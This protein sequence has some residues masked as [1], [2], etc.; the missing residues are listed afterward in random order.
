MALGVVGQAALFDGPN[1]LAI[2]TVALVAIGLVAIGAARRGAARRAATGLAVL[3]LAFS[4]LAVIGR[5]DGL[6][7]PMS[8]A[9]SLESFANAVATAANGT[10]VGADLTHAN[11]K[12][13]GMLGYQW[14]R[15]DLR[16][17][18]LE[19]DE[20]PLGP[21][22]I[23]PLR[24]ERLLGLGA[25]LVEIDPS[26]P[27]GLYV[28]PGAEQEARQRGALLPSDFPAVLPV[29]AAKAV[30]EGPAEVRAAAG[31]PAI[32]NLTVHHRGTDFRWPRFESEGAGFS[33]ARIR[34]GARV[35]PTA[36]QASPSP[37]PLFAVLPQDLLPGQ[38]AD[39]SLDLGRLRLGGAPFSPGEYRVH[40]E[41]HQVGVGWFSDRYD[42]VPFVLRLIVSSPGWVARTVVP[43]PHRI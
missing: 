23:G 20:R 29:Q 18:D 27:V 15:P 21:W 14:F 38:Q 26:R 35:V 16:L 40:V 34:V 33:Q 8:L 6:S 30:I 4:T 39:L 1:G 24:W 36:G 3:V 32:M 7:T 22:A 13:V 19:D 17:Y 11:S 2:A 12:D 31:R 42:Q 37:K 25:E 10:P 43:K 5:Y 41:L 9:G 28:L